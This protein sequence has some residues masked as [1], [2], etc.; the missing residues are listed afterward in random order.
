M[1][2][3]FIFAYIT[4]FILEFVCHLVTFV[5]E[6]KANSCSWSS[7]VTLDQREASSQNGLKEEQQA[8]TGLDVTGW[9]TSGLRSHFTLPGQSKIRMNGVFHIIPNSNFFILWNES[10]WGTGTVKHQKRQ[11]IAQHRKS[12]M[13][14]VLLYNPNHLSLWEVLA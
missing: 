13:N 12:V 10:G 3:K 6:C 14:I 9:S 1:N 4:A 11:Q 5:Q 8:W 2:H 7:S